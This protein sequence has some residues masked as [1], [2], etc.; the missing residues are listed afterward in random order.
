VW[1][2]A[3]HLNASIGSVAS[4]RFQNQQELLRKHGG[5]HWWLIVE[6]NRLDRYYVREKG[7]TT[8]AL[9]IGIGC[10]EIVIRP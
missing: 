5:L 1:R 6:Q 8:L 10:K 7:S 2:G 4:E 3:D 9:Y